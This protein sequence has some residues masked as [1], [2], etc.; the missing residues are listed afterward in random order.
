[1]TLKK[2]FDTVCHSKLLA[3]LISYG[4]CGNALAWIEAFLCCRSQSV[5]ICQSSS[6]PKSVI[7]GVP[8]GSVFGPHAIFL[9][10]IND[11]VYIFNDLPVSLSLFADDSLIKLMQLMMICRLQLI[12]LL[13]GLDYG[14]Y[15]LLYQSISV[16]ELLIHSGNWLTQL[17]TSFTTLRM[18]NVLPFSDHIRDLGIYHDTRLKY[19]QYN[20]S[21][22]VHKAYTRAVLILKCFHSRD[23]SVLMQAFGV[24]VRPLLEFSSQVW[25]P[26]HKYN[27]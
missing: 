27:S 2:A 4:I 9:L 7:S 18:D 25:S 8:Q 20:I 22:I 5:R 12:D 15:R 10:F 19:D 23:S 16:S 3:K 24:Y 1:L 26:H 21:F 11:L 17:I 6:T 14:S 13:T